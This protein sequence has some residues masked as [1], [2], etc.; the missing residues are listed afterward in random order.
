MDSTRRS[1]LSAHTAGGAGVGRA[2][3]GA[4][5]AGFGS[6]GADVDGGKLLGDLLR[7]ALGASYPG[8]GG[9]T[10]DQAVEGRAAGVAKIFVNGHKTPDELQEVNGL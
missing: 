4:G 1:H 7:A 10:G 9:G 6:R 5:F 8:R 2:W 3:S